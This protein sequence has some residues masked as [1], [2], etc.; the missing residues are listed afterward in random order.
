MKSYRITGRLDRAGMTASVVCAVHCALLPLVIT[1]LPLWGLEFLA[2]EWVELFM[3]GLALIIGILSLS[4][5]FKKH[6]QRKM[7]LLLLTAGFGIIVIGHLSHS[8]LLEPILI[9]TGGLTIAVAHYIN[10]RFSACR[11]HP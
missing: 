1:L 6:H 8:A 11:M 5:S 3:I 7:P 9:P 4:V 10:W 2:E